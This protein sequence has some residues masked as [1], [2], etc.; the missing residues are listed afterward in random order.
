[1]KEVAVKKKKGWFHRELP[2]HIMLLPAVVITFIFRYIPFA[3]ITMAFEDYTP[4]KGIFH[5][6]SVFTARLFKCNLEYY[7]YCCDENGR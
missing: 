4:L 7:F 2:F 5:Q 3:G 1:M 6:K